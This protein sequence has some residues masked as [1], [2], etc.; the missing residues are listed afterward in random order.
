MLPGA[1]QFSK[2]VAALGIGRDDTIVV[3][4]GI[5]LGG[6]PRGWWTFRIFGAKNVY[7]LDGG[8]PKWKAEGRPTEPGASAAHAAQFE[9]ELNTKVV[10]GVPD[11]QMALLDK[12]TP[13]WSTRGLRRASAAK[14]PSRGPASVRGTCRRRQR[15]CR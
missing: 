4:D 13:R 7:I 1:K 6:A 2:E 11:V 10:A 9:A 12:T 14:V 3:Y 5:G 8:L 15:T